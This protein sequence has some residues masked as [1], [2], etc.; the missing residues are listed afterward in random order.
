VRVWEEDDDVRPK[1]R[2]QREQKCFYTRDM[3][4]KNHEEIIQYKRNH[5][6]GIKKMEKKRGC[7]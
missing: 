2:K 3:N 7:D 1:T 4:R 6:R 5:L